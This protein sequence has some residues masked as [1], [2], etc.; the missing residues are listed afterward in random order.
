MKRKKDFL[1]A[2]DILISIIIDLGN[3]S[4]QKLTLIHKLKETG[5]YRFLS[6]ADDAWRAVRYHANGRIEYLGGTG[7]TS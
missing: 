2:Y 4:T 6:T 5:Y 1:L 3:L 7:P